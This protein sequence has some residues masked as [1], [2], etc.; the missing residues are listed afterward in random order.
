MA[1]KHDSFAAAR[2]IVVVI[3]VGEIQSFHVLDVDAF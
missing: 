2:H 1:Q 3:Q